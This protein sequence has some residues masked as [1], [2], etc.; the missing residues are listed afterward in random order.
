MTDGGRVALY[1]QDKHPIREGMEY[2]R[3]AEERGDAWQ[4]RIE[5]H[6]RIAWLSRETQRAL[7]ELGREDL[8]TELR[9]D[10]GKVT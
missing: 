10:S 2:V 5:F 8:A 3:Y 9:A 7:V 6:D 4:V 1:L